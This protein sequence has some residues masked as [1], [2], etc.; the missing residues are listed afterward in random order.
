MHIIVK[1]GRKSKRSVLTRDNS[2]RSLSPVAEWERKLAAHTRQVEKDF[3]S[4]TGKS[5]LLDGDVFEGWDCQ[6]KKDRKKRKRYVR[7]GRN[8]KSG[9]NRR[10]AAAKGT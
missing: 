2:G 8:A 6:R 10:R 3:E 1:G 5:A 4:Q 9:K 7:L